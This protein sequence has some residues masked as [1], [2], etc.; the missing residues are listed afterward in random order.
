MNRMRL[1]NLT[2][3]QRGMLQLQN[4]DLDLYLLDLLETLWLGV[5]SSFYD[6]GTDV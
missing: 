4:T 5:L 1:M 6:G 2:L 3:R